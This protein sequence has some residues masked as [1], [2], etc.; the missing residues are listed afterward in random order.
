M[1]DVMAWSLEQMAELHYSSN[2][3]QF[4]TDKE[5]EF[6]AER[7]AEEYLET[8]NDLYVDALNELDYTSL[9]IASVKGSIVLEDFFCEE[10]CELIKAV[11]QKLA[12]DWYKERYKYD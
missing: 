3:P 12:E 7:C 1:G 5:V 9:Y 11:G 4:Q 8:F 2:D 6:D 10:S